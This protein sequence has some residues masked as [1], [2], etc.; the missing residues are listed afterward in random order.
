M[1]DWSDG[2]ATTPA[3]D[4]VAASLAESSAASSAASLMPTSGLLYF[5]V[6]LPSVVNDSYIA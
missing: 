6:S 2:E 1:E 4:Y 3:S 5:K